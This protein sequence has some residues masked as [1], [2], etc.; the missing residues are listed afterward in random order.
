MRKSVKR[1]VA[2]GVVAV[3]LVLGGVGVAAA[4]TGAALPS[5]TS[6]PG[7]GGES[8]EHD[9]PIAGTITA[10][11]EAAEAA[12]GTETA[13]DEKARDAAESKALEA[14]AKITPDEAKAAALK[15]VPGT[16]GQ[17]ELEEEDGFVVYQVDI[18]GKDSTITEVIIDAGNGT[19]LA[20]ETEDADEANE[21]S[22]ANEANETPDANDVTD[23]PT[24]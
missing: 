16:A 20:Q 13:A 19:V 5:T 18:T 10:P 4:T 21:A 3:G 15:A 6:A 11:P 8:Q 23:A 2:T 17:V 12:E 9:T 14:L 22:D 7:T 1:T 24:T